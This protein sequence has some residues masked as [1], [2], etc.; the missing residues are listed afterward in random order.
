M[1]RPWPQNAL[2]VVDKA[3]KTLTVTPAYYVFRHV[4]QFVDP[5]AKR[6]ATTGG[7]ALAFKNP[8]GTLVAVLRNAGGAKKTVVALGGKKLEFDIPGNGWA[9]VKLAP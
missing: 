6:V 8:D 7:D 1:Q 2:L 9:T 4:S 5:G 3:T